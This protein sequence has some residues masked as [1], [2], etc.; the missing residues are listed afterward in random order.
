MKNIYLL[1]LLCSFVF[2]PLLAVAQTEA[3]N[4]EQTQTSETTN[5]KIA[6]TQRDYENTE[7]SMA[8]V[9]REDGKIYVVVAVLT[10]IFSG[11]VVFLVVTESKLKKLEDLVY[12]EGNFKSKI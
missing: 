5:G 6:I 4:T 3:E 11:I 12:S 9:F 1:L 7:I 2:S 10:T 8:D